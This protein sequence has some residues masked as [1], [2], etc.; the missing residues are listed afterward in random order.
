M[1]H[2]KVM[3]ESYDGKRTEQTMKLTQ[4]VYLIPLGLGLT[5]CASLPRGTM[6]E[7]VGPGPAPASVGQT[8]GMLQV[9]S[10]RAPAPLDVEMQTDVARRDSFPA[11]NDPLKRDLLHSTAHTGYR[12][13]TTEHRLLRRVTNAKGMNDPRPT[14]VPLPPGEYLVEADTEEFDSGLHPVLVPVLLKSSSACPMGMR[15]GGG[16]RPRKFPSHN[17][18]P[19]VEHEDP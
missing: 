13:Y 7:P 3:P 12:I 9:Y 10:A 8:S 15:W 17:E 4:L 5:S 18:N 16:L 1:G 6:L 14:I 2:S 19:P 11:E